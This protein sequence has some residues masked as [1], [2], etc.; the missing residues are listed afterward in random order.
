MNA[1]K[2]DATEFHSQIRDKFVDGYRVKKDFKDRYNIWTS[3]IDR[4]GIVGQKVLDAGC[5]P[6]H[7]SFYCASKRCGVT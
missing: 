4:L 6:G 3:L 7:L 5:G 2:N 1:L